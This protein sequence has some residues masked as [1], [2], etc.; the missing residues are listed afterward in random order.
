MSTKQ[1]TSSE[2]ASLWTGYMQNTMTKCVM[3][4]F[5]AK[6]EDPDIQSCIQQ[7]YDL[8][9]SNIKVITEIYTQEGMQIPVGFSNQDV[10]L[11][12][13]RLF[14][15]T[16]FLMYIHHMGKIGLVQYS[17]LQAMS[18]RRD[19]ATFFAQALKSTS[20]LHDQASELSLEKG[21]LIRPPYIP[22]PKS[23][24]FVQ[25]R[26]Y[27]SGNSIFSDKRPLNAIEI[28]HLFSNLQTNLLGMMLSVGFAQTAKSKE[29]RDYMYRGAA[30]AKKHMKIFAN[31]L[32]ESEVQAP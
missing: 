30:V 5:L 16:F 21:L 18:V 27:F 28:S 10:H 20:D 32:I 15:D 13:S 24:E 9:E 31:H 25:N 7:S 26:S 3:E 2:I 4:Y 8:A 12:A 23:V 14:S 29:V 6:V 22:E 11:Q 19:I 1:L 17:L